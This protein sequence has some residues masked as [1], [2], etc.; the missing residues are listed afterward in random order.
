LLASAQFFQIFL[1]A[2]APLIGGTQGIS[3][4][5]FF[6]WAGSGIGVRDVAVLG[7]LSVFAISVFVFVERVARSPLG[8]TL[9]AVRDNE[10]A[11]RALERSDVAI[12]RNVIVRVAVVVGYEGW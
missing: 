1:G 7:F 9:R 8:R 4:P 12:R 10:L 11:S 3:V 6:G 5:N 2:Y